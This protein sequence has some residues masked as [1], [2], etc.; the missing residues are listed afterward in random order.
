MQRPSLDP[1]VAC[2]DTE[3]PTAEQAYT[4]Y[5]W[6]YRSKLHNRAATGVV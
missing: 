5:E 6:K 1:I 2:I 3:N 4:L